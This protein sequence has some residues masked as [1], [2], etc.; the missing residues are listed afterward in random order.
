MRLLITGGMGFIGSNFIRYMLEKY[1]DY[2]IVNLDKLTYAGNLDNLKDVEEK[3]GNNRIPLSSR[4][5]PTPFM[6]GGTG[7]N[8]LS[9]Y[10]FVQGDIA[11]PEDVK[12]AIGDG[13][14]G[15]INFAAE[16]HVDRSLYDPLSF[17]KTDVEGTYVLLQAAKDYGIK[18]FHQVSTDEVYGDILE[19][20]SKETDSLR[21]SSPYSA[22]KAGGDLQVLAAYRTFGLPVTITRGSNTYGPYHYPEKIIPL[23]ITNALENK[24]LPVY[25]GGTQVRDWLYVLDHCRA[26]DVVF[27]HGELGHVYNAGANQD[28]EITNLVLT[29]QI[30][31]L[32]GKDETIIKN[33]NGLRPGHD[34]R[35][36]LNC[37]KIRAL[38]WKPEVEFE[39]GLRLTVE[40]FKNNE[41]W[42]RKIKNGEYLEYYK[43][44]YNK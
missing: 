2:E 19:G 1:P 27:H 9:R 14:D 36:A 15:I 12:K 37:D 24:K 33:V 25:D 44:H 16:S 26:I 5:S 39:D 6:K 3:Y 11:N 31:E 18:R 7:R 17:I 29:K 4:I 21:P 35:Y 38:G 41:D 23:F 43:K 28:P 42:W 10:T 32:T 40:W 8:N 22:S 30:L 13:V 34:Q 20:F